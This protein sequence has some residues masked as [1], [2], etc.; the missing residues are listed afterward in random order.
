[1]SN[2]KDFEIVII[3]NS[4]GELSSLVKPA[5]KRIKIEIPNAKI[6]AVLTPCQYS[7][8]LEVEYLKSFPEV[9]QVISSEQY[10]N[11]IFLKKQIPFSFSDKGIIIFL[12]GDLMH[13]VTVSKKLKYKAIAYIVERFGWKNAYSKFLLPS[14]EK[15]REMMKKGFPEN[16]LEVIGDLMADS[17]EKENKDNLRKLWKIDPK[18]QVLCFF[19]GSRLWQ[20][21][22][23]VPFYTEVI[24]LVKK[25]HPNVQTIL[26]V[27]PFVKVET[28]EKIV[29][30]DS[31]D[32]MGPL[33]LAQVADLAITIPGTNTAHLA[34][35]EVPMLTI[36]PL[37]HAKVI[38][39][40]GIMNIFGKIPVLGNLL[41]HGIARSLLRKK[42][43]FSLPNINLNQYIVPEM[44][45]NVFPR[46]VAFRVFSLL[47][48]KNLRDS[49]V[50]R[51]KGAFGERGASHKLVD[52]IKKEA[53][54]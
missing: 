54:V 43:Y 31:F 45:G 3:A 29:P 6:T 41:K 28:I 17:V 44:A 16:K 34:L 24:K 7:S 8:G 36:F 27:S 49:I 15:K 35:L 19:P 2:F 20:I 47:G 38:P 53:F 10:F 14:E 22:H 32:I 25:E 39:L 9:K 52:V 23:M 33:S 46:E 42:K 12:G 40:E 26:A 50:E 1:M 37:Q 21:E 51:T 5:V 11:W 48:D 30:H 4:P 18:N 13:G